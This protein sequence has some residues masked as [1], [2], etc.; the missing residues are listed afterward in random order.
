MTYRDYV[1]N[2][3]HRNYYSTEYY[4]QYL[5]SNRV[6][7]QT[8]NVAA[9]P[10]TW[11]AYTPHAARG[12]DFAWGGILEL[13]APAIPGAANAVTANVGNAM[14]NY[15]Y[16][17]SYGASLGIEAKALSDTPANICPNGQG[18]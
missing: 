1:P 8:A 12:T 5:M 18:F 3:G 9:T 7:T 14:R 13:Y 4:G 6:T 2:A 11:M 17:N 15:V 10:S 16:W